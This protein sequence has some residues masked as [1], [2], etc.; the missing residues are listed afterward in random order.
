MELILCQY[1]YC[2]LRRTSRRSDADGLLFHE[3]SKHGS[4]HRSDIMLA[5]VPP[6]RPM[7]AYSEN[8]S[9][10]SD[11]SLSANL[12]QMPSP[13]CKAHMLCNQRPICQFSRCTANSSGP[14]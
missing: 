5:F 9:T 4:I 13:L 1:T 3:I 12:P 2:R 6:I 11:N 8:S 7:I 10:Y 14:Q